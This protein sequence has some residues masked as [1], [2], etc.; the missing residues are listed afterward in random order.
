MGIR[1]LRP[2]LNRR[3][4]FG[5]LLMFLMPL[6]GA[7]LSTSVLAGSS[8]GLVDG[9]ILIYY[10]RCCVYRL[11]NH[12]RCGW[13]GTGTNAQFKGVWQVRQYRDGSNIIVVDHGNK[14]IRKVSL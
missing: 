5:V 11:Y 14:R 3:G 10:L 7:Y 2:L 8:S 6:A 13:A 1:L 12:S 9:T 4:V